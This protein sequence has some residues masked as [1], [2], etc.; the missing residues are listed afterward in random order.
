[1][2]TQV[3]PQ[4]RRVIDYYRDLLIEA[5]DTKG[6]RLR[7]DPETLAF[8]LVRVAESFLWTDLI[9]GEEPDL[10]KAREVARMILSGDAV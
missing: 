1:M 5:R 10:T 2:T 7:L 9:T 3:S 6:L 8:V 4:Q